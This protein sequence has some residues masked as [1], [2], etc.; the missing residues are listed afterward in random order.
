MFENNW[1]SIKRQIFN[2]APFSSQEQRD[3]GKILSLLKSNN[4]ANW[5]VG[6][7]QIYSNKIIN[8]ATAYNEYRAQREL[9]FLGTDPSSMSAASIFVGGYAFSTVKNFQQLAQLKNLAF[10]MV[11][12]EVGLEE[13][14]LEVFGLTNLKELHLNYKGGIIKHIPAEIAQLQNLEVL[15]ITYHMI[16]HLPPEIK[17]LKKLKVLDI[18]TTCV[19][20]LPDTLFE[21]ENLELLSLPMEDAEDIPAE[22]SRLQKLKYLE[23]MCYEDEELERLKGRFPHLQIGEFPDFQDLY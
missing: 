4:E 19:E 7:N 16:E 18:N 12:D 17:C 8:Y 11:M 6:L 3:W 9:Y 20:A 21:L 15:S 5:K 10:I 23:V 2:A 14:P 1:K 22:I 13:L